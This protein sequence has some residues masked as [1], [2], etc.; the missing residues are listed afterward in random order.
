MTRVVACASRVTGG[1]IFQGG[2]VDV[3]FPPVIGFVAGGALLGEMVRGGIG[4][5]TVETSFEIV[6]A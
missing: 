2:V 4:C 3:D 5:M 1:T 6:A